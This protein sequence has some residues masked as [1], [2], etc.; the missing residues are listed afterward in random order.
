MKRKGLVLS[1]LL[2]GALAISGC[3][4]S[5]GEVIQIDNNTDSSLSSGEDN[6]GEEGNSS[7]ITASVDE[8]YD[9]AVGQIKEFDGNYVH[10]IFGD[11]IEIFQVDKENSSSFYIGESV[12]LAKDG[13]KFIL[14]S[15]LKDDFSNKFTSMGSKIETIKGEIAKSDSEDMITILSDEGK[16]SFKYSSDMEYALGTKVSVDYFKLNPDSDD[17]YLTSI[18]NEDSKLEL[19]VDS[20]ERNEAGYMIIRA[21]EARESSEVSYVISLSDSSDLNFNRSELKADDK[22]LVYAD[23]IMESYPAQVNAL[24]VLLDKE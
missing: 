16:F 10:I 13:D 15:Y 2:I 1:L 22:I 5:K 9:G 17:M 6:N 23:M 24:K 7:E 20:I 21:K 14:E 18:Y 11:M 3:T 19:Y 12:K 8:G 4:S